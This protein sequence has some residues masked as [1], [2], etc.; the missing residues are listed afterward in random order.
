SDRE[1]RL[2]EAQRLE[3]MGQLTGGVAHD[4]NNVLTAIIGYSDLLMEQIGPDKA[5]GRDVK[6]ILSAAHRAASLTHQLLA[7]SRRQDLPVRVINPNDVVRET[8]AMLRRLLSERIAIV[9]QLAGNLRSIE[10]NPSQLEQILVNLSVNARD[11]MAG[12]GT[13][14]IETV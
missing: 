8:E 11:A 13:L 6:E 2:L 14:M 7:F 12:G 9:T 10:A 3:A 1:E 4:F 5:I